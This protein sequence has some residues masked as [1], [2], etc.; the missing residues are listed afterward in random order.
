[1]KLIIEFDNQDSNVFQVKGNKCLLKNTNKRISGRVNRRK[2]STKSYYTKRIE[3]LNEKIDNLNKKLDEITKKT[4][5]SEQTMKKPNRNCNSEGTYDY[6]HEIKDCLNETFESVN[7]LNNYFNLV[8]I[9]DE[10]DNNSTRIIEHDRPKSN[11]TNRHEPYKTQND[12][13]KYFKQSLNS[14]QACSERKNSKYTSLDEACNNILRNYRDKQTK[15]SKTRTMETF[16]PTVE[17][18]QYLLPINISSF[19][20]TPSSISSI[21]N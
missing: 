20:D 8:S 13:M 16:D 18:T 19:A 21:S 4:S 5:I 6:K 14:I 9:S 12:L 17:L 15:I 3:N 10:S 2:I 11:L 7:D 1:M